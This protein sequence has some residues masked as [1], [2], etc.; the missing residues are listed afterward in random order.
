MQTG[1]ALMGSFSIL[2]LLGLG[3]TPALASSEQPHAATTCIPDDSTPT[4][5][6]SAGSGKITFKG[7]ATGVID[8]WCDISNPADSAHGN[9]SWTTLLLTNKDGGPRSWVEARLYKKHRITGATMT[10]LTLTSSDQDAIKEDSKALPAPL[11]FNQYGYFLRVRLQRS[12]AAANPEFHAVTLGSPLMLTLN[13]AMVG[14]H[15]TVVQL[16]YAGKI[17]PGGNL[18]QPGSVP[19]QT[20]D[21]KNLVIYAVNTYSDPVVD[22][23]PNCASDVTGSAQG[24]GLYMLS[25]L[26]NAAGAVTINMTATYPT[27]L[28]IACP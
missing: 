12:T 26:P 2:G 17:V 16:D 9:P 14:A 4:G 27:A 13:V 23:A 7:S 22:L 25:F 21:P 20:N 15:D 10:E 24:N 3:M 1:L 19:Y 5:K 28:T 6:Y 8:F 18:Y 11:D